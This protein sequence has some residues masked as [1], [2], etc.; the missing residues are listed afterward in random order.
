MNFIPWPMQIY[1]RVK[2]ILLIHMYE[3]LPKTFC[4]HKRIVYPLDLELWD[5]VMIP[6]PFME[7][8]LW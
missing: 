2:T 3:A 7:L 8:L 4:F 6:D 5:C 1:V